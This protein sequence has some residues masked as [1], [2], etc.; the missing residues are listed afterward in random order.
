ME[1][2]PD[3]IGPGT[4]VCSIYKYFKEQ[5]S[6]TIPLFLQ[7][8]SAKE[9]CIYIAEKAAQEQL[10]NEFVEKKPEVKKIVESGQLVLLD[11]GTT[12]LK[13][14]NLDIDRTINA[15]RDTERK[16]LSEGFSGVRVCGELP[17]VSGRP[18]DDDT[19]IN[20]ELN[21]DKYIS[22]SKLVAICHYC[23]DKYNPQT[24]AK[25]IKHHRFVAIYGNCYE[26]KFYLQEEAA[27]ENYT[28]IINAILEG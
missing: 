6:V 20:Y 17:F 16:A 13:D 22:T 3:K 10:M 9:K 2:K 21:V 23:E 24:L 7:G 12:Y 26:N 18:I 8:L 27:P 14:G 4:H 5:I 28:S 1:V 15:I 11:G 19:I 25:I